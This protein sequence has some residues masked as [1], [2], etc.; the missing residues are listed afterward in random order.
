M[1]R[2]LGCPMLPPCNLGSDCRCDCYDESR[3]SDV[4]GWVLIGGGLIALAA[5]SLYLVVMIG[6]TVQQ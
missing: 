1:P 3:H 6:A 2:S 5:L 4:V